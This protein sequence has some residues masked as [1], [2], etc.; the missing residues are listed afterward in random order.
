[1]IE[2]SD[3]LSMS[4]Y[5]Y[6]QPFTGSC[7]GMRYRIMMCKRETGK[8]ADDKPVIEK[9]FEVNTWPEPYSFENTEPEN[10][11]AKEFPFTEEGYA[12]LLNHLNA[13]IPNYADSVRVYNIRVSK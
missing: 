4:F 6:G 9:Y 3:I 12:D 7:E 11:S 10:I 13:S 1:M 8:D 2:A 5:S